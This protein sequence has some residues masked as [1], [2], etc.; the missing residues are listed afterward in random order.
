MTPEITR[1]RI[2]DCMRFPTA[3]NIAQFLAFQGESIPE[4]F[5]V[6]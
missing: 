4:P 6:T 2:Y 3:K 1:C 5:G